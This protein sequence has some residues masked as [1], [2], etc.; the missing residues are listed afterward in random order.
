LVSSYF[1]RLA[2]TTGL[3]VGADAVRA[4]GSAAPA[5]AP[6]GGEMPAPPHVEQ[7][8]LVAPPPATPA[9]DTASSAGSGLPL[10]LV[11]E[12][13]PSSVQGEGFDSRHARA[14]LAARTVGE[15]GPTRQ[16]HATLPPTFVETPRPALFEEARLEF[17]P[18]A[19]VPSPRE[20]TRTSR[21]GEH[22]SS[23]RAQP[24]EESAARGDAFT[25]ALA[26]LGVRAEAREPAYAPRPLAQPPDSPAQADVRHAY[27]RE[28]VEWIN[29]P[30]N[31]AQGDAALAD[32]HLT[33]TEL[34]QG[35]SGRT[36]ATRARA[37]AARELEVQD[38]SLSIG[39]ISVVIEEPPKQ[40]H[41]TASVQSPEP[42]RGAAS[43]V[44]TSRLR[45]HYVRGL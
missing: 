27:L 14:P 28:V 42:G 26:P 31:A 38:F 15:E 34:A 11:R 16:E 3:R 45:R 23:P 9:G 29:A 8:T 40:T 39:S 35:D 13:G 1:S 4:V 37:D 43:P 5:P 10:G 12:R 20:E 7:V 17:V 19:S 36:A 24:S 25:Q 41:T 33:S 44:E 18:R 6:A 22:E 32:D 2:N 30:T 21:R